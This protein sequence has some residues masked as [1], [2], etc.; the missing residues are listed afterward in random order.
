[1]TQPQYSYVMISSDTWLI[2]IRTGKA[3]IHQ[4]VF[5]KPPGMN[6]RL[7]GRLRGQHAARRRRDTIC[8]RSS[9]VELWPHGAADSAVPNGVL[10]ARQR[11]YVHMQILKRPK[12][13]GGNSSKRG[14][15]RSSKQAWVK[16]A[17][18]RTPRFGQSDCVHAAPLAGLLFQLPRCKCRRA[19]CAC[20]G[21]LHGTWP[22][23]VRLN[24]QVAQLSSDLLGRCSCGT[25][26]ASVASGTST[27]V[28]RRWCRSWRPGAPRNAVDGVARKSW[29]VNRSCGRV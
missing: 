10:E 22:G 13:D 25:G 4:A 20:P 28:A 1:M 26:S 23:G 11:R 24:R 16:P 5:A 6:C 12:A 17:Q 8:Y 2:E 9:V 29:P 14:D 19:S 15:Y 18:H 3:W 7:R 27:G 21:W